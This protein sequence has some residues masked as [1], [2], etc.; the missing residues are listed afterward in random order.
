MSTGA[1]SPDGVTLASAAADFTVRL[2]PSAGAF[3]K[4][5]STP[6]APSVSVPNIVVPNIV[7]PSVNIPNIVVPNI[8]V[9]SVNVPSVN[10]PSV[11]VPSVNVPSVNVPNIVVPSINVPNIVMPSINMPNTV[12]PGVPDAADN[13]AMPAASPESSMADYAAQATQQISAFAGAAETLANLAQHAKPSDS[14]W[15]RDLNAQLAAMDLADVALLEIVPPAEAAALHEQI[16]GG[17]WGCSDARVL[18]AGQLAGEGT[19]KWQDVATAMEACRAAMATAQALLDE[20]ARVCSC[21][22]SARY[23]YTCSAAGT[24][25]ILCTGRRRTEQHPRGARSAIDRAA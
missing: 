8:V 13:S 14:G 25:R 20:Q 23:A 2:W 15:L 12:A 1:A 3:A 9:P 7:V 22:A 16:I 21:A 18:V 5:A 6:T 17:T 24:D 10:V 11:N 19:A 4:A